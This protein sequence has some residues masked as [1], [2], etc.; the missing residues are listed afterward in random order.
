MSNFLPNYLYRYLRSNITPERLSSLLIES[1]LYLNSRA[2]FNDP[3]DSTAYIQTVDSKQKLRKKF[4]Y[5][6][7]R[8][9]K[10]KNQ[11]IDQITVKNLVSNQ[12]MKFKNTPFYL[13]DFM[14]SNINKIGIYCL[15]EDNKNI[16]MWSHYATNHEGLILEFDVAE[17][18][19]TFSQ[20]YKVDYSKNYPTLSFL[21]K[22]KNEHHE[23]LTTKSIDW[24][25]EKEW[26]IIRVNEAFNNL[27]F[28]PKALTS[29]T[30]GCRSGV[31]IRNLVSELLVERA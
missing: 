15:S 24:E 3:F 8:G 10:E 31:S 28:N 20:T 29:V 11:I 14:V 1:R 12:M 21:N 7:R 23:L 27:A 9:L 5:L 6:I 30:F 16:L 26:R 19:A 13:E 17:T 2:Q 4:E 22:N 18:S 25:Y